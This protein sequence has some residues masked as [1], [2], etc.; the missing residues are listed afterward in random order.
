MKIVLKSEDFPEGCCPYLQMRFEFTTSGRLR[1]PDVQS[2]M[3]AEIYGGSHSLHFYPARNEKPDYQK[4][5]VSLDLEIEFSLDFLRRIFNDDLKVFG[6]FEKNMEKNRLAIMG[7]RSFPITSAM[8]FI[9]AQIGDCKFTGTLKRVFVEAKV[10]ELLTLQIDQI[11]AFD[12][13]NKGLK[14][15]DIDKLNEVRDLL[16]KNIYSPFSIEEL[17]KIA[18]INRTKLQEGFKEL[19]GTTIFGYI[20]DIRLEE[21]RQRIQHGKREVSIADIAAMAGYKNPQHFT[22]AFKRKFGFLPKEVK[23]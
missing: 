19:F 21:A 18:G 23:G 20:S 7:N 1:N 12:H 22:A 11:N 16:L 5:P 9:L 2:G 10:L 3:A 8:K 14:K 17:S 15:V 6:G 13:G 4:K